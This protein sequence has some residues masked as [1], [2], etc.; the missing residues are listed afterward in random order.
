MNKTLKYVLVAF[1]ALIL[2]TVIGRSLGWIGTKKGLEVETSKV[3][4]RTIIE[5][6][7]ASGKIQPEAEVKLS[8]E[9]SGEIIELP[10]KEGEQVTK[11]QLLVRINPDIYQAAV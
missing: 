4:Q 1:F 5:T 7:T 6:V 11:G 9:V 10:I 8:P 3:V 2:F